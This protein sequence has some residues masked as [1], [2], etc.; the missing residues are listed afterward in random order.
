MPWEWGKKVSFHETKGPPKVWAGGQRPQ[1]VGLRPVLGNQPEEVKVPQLAEGRW[2][3]RD[4][5][6]IPS[7]SFELERYLR[8]ESTK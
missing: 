3:W 7:L 4:F 8:D 5:Q 1:P 6:A 2:Q